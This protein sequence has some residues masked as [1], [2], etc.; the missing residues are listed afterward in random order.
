DLE[1]I[2]RVVLPVLRVPV[3]GEQAAQRGDELL[4]AHV[5]LV[6]LEPGQAELHELVLEP[7]GDDVD[8][9]AAAGEMIGGDQPLGEHPGMPH[10]GWKAAITFRRSV[11][12]SRAT[13]KAEASCCLSA[14]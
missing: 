4:G 14:P 5:A 6:V 9:G 3:L 1:A 2:D 13:E 8:R 7:A 11:A 12:P 10:A